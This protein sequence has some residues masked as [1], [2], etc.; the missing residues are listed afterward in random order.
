MPHRG[1]RDRTG[2]FGLRGSAL[3]PENLDAATLQFH[4]ARSPQPQ[5]ALLRG[6]DCAWL[7][8]TTLCD[9]ALIAADGEST[10]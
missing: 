5:L 2:A 10:G 7:I 4:D 8:R 9:G 6:G 3:D 1:R